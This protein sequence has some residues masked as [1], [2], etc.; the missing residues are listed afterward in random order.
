MGFWDYFKDE[1][2][3]ALFRFWRFFFFGMYSFST[4]TFSL[5][6]DGMV[7]LLSYLMT[8]LG[9]WVSY[10]KDEAGVSSKDITTQ[11]LQKNE[12]VYKWGKGII[13]QM[14]IAQAQR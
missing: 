3:L 13:I 11:C 12:S 1:L 8:I 2:I 9:Q 10:W 14:V 4:C 7:Y 6:S 5:S